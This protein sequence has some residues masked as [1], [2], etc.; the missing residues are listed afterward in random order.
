MGAGY[1]CF[2]ID[3]TIDAY[4]DQTRAL[5][6]ALRAAGHQVD[7]LS[8][9]EGDVVTPDDLAMKQTYL[10]NLGFDQ[11]VT[12]E[13]LNLVAEPHDIN[14]AIFCADNGVDV[15]FDNN[16][17]NAKAVAAT[18]LPLVPWPTREK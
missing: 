17:A 6:I 9:I 3:G 10:S 4:P 5:M 11:G 18:T 15:L 16:K 8:G 1:F 2:D 12:Y 14:K 13:N 7:V